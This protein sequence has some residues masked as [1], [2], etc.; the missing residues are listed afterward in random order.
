MPKNRQDIDSKKGGI[1]LTLLL[2]ISVVLLLI[3]PGIISLLWYHSYVKDELVHSYQKE[4]LAKI[5]LIK[6][7]FEYEYDVRPDHFLMELS[8]FISDDPQLENLIVFSTSH[9]YLFSAKSNNIRDFEHYANLASNRNLRNSTIFEKVLLETKDNEYIAFFEINNE[10][11]YNQIVSFRN[12]LISRSIMTSVFI[13]LIF[14]VII[15]LIFRPLTH[16]N[17]ELAEISDSEITKKLSANY[18][19]KD[20]HII[21]DNINKIIK[22]VS[23]S[24]SNLINELKDNTRTLQIQNEELKIAKQKAEESNRLKSE[25]VANVSHEIRTPMN[26]IIGFSDILKDKI[27]DDEQKFYLDSIISSGKT[28]LNLINDILDFSKIESGKLNL[29]YDSINIKNVFNELVSIFSLKAKEKNLDFLSYYDLNLPEYLILDEYRM[30]QIATN[31]L[32]NAIKFT[33]TGWVKF[34]MYLSQYNPI[35]SSIDLQIIVE[36][37]GIGIS[38]ADQNI[39]FLPFVQQSGQSTRKYGG[40]GLGLAITKQ[41][42]TMMNGDIKLESIPGRGSKFTIDFKKIIVSSVKE[43]KLSVPKNKY[44]FEPAKIL[45]VDDIELNRTLLKELF[46]RSALEFLD[47]A[48]GLEAIAKAQEFLPDLIVMD[49]KM[50]RMDG[51]DA[52]TTIKNN[53]ETKNIPIIALTASAMHSEREHYAKLGF[54]AVLIKP[55]EKQVITDTFRKYLK[56]KEINFVDNDV[57]NIHTTNILSTNNEI[58]HILPINLE[59]NEQAYLI[60]QIIPKAEALRDTLIISDVKKLAEDIQSFGLKNN[61]TSMIELS[62][63]INEYASRFQLEQLKLILLEIVQL[64]DKIDIN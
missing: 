62:E 56:Y 23:S 55:V 58:Q 52:T 41:L 18:R 20:F 29:E 63:R 45:L 26:A 46:A 25:F 14:F 40:T 36:D 59:V 49:I 10:Q 44:D 2:F 4:Y 21:A 47:A 31:L 28:L 60:N 24:Q 1:S 7:E 19:I 30:K 50:P 9:Q 6:N 33:E 38:E 64:K 43:S 48:D 53:P 12:I 39:I 61:I 15:S 57:I 32:S 51:I 11:L 5:E 13:I 8:N 17:S 3:V 54:D 37:S 16:L 35:T 27:N 34:S 22:K 42:I